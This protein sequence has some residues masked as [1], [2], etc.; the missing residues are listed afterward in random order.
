M[1]RGRQRAYDTETVRAS[2]SFTKAQ[3]ETLERIAQK[4]KVSLA[5]VVR[6]AVEVYLKKERS[7]LSELSSDQ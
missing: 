3:Y 2:V 5:W 7:H 6:D 1:V 4:K